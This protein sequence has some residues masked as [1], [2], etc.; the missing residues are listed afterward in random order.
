MSSKKC[1]RLSVWSSLFGT[2]FLVYGD[3]S[4][5]SRP[6]CVKLWPYLKGLALT[7]NVATFVLQNF[8]PRWANISNSALSQKYHLHVI[9]RKETEFL[10]SVQSLSRSS[11]GEEGL[12]QTIM[13]VLALNN[14]SLL[15]WGCI[16]LLMG[17]P[18]LTFMRRYWTV[19][20]FTQRTVSKGET[21]RKLVPSKVASGLLCSN[22]TPE[23]CQ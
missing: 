20:F 22:E 5:M 6:H 10:C 23:I 21:E 15:L 14:N 16:S 17:K 12:Y 9:N 3:S 7:V 11:K 13:P 4:Y 19:L 8:D 18:S 1:C 2:E